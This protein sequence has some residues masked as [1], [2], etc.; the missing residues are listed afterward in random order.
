MSALCDCQRKW[1]RLQFCGTKLKSSQSVSLPTQRYGEGAHAECVQKVTIEPPPFE[2]RCSVCSHPTVYNCKKIILASTSE[3]LKWD[4]ND[5]CT[6]C[7]ESVRLPNEIRE[8]YDRC[9]H[10][11]LLLKKSDNVKISDHRYVHNYCHSLNRS[12]QDKRTEY[13]EL[14]EKLSQSKS[15]LKGLRSFNT[16]MSIAFGVCGGIILLACIRFQTAFLYNLLVTLMISIPILIILYG[17]FSINRT[18]YLEKEIKRLTEKLG[19]KL[20]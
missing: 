10:C 3:W 15:S 13:I 20:D 5:R 9:D 14:I 1:G 2:V 6:N 7:G 8:S 18:E 11:K 12:L 19:R 17:P 4:G 16:F